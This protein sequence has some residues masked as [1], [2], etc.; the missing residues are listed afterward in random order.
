MAPSALPDL[1]RL[2]GCV[3]VSGI[4]MYKLLGAKETVFLLPG[5]MREAVKR[6]VIALSSMILLG[7]VE[8]LVTVLSWFFIYLDASA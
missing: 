3:P 8:W 1:A 4:N 5:G 6:K 7:V 2:L